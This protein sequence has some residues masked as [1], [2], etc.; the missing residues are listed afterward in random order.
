MWNL[1]RMRA[2][3]LIDDPEDDV[4]AEGEWWTDGEYRRDYCEHCQYKRE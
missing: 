3:H 1:A 4:K 2:W